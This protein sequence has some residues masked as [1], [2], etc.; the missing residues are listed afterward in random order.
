MFPRVEAR[1]LPYLQVE[2]DGY[3]GIGN[4]ETHTGKACIRQQVRQNVKDA[5]DMLYERYKEDALKQKTQ[6]CIDTI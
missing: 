1:R 5:L 2:R 3:K 4:T 6:D